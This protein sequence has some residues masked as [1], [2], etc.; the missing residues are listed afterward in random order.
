MV[1]K[2]ILSLAVLGMLTSCGGDNGTSKTNP[3]MEKSTL[4]YQA[5]D[6]S[7]IKAEHFLPAFKAGMAE[8]LSEI[9]SIVAN[10]EAPSF[11]NTIVAL[12]KS[13]RLLSRTSMTF[14]GLSGAHG[15]DEIRKVQTEV[16]PLLS[17]H[18][19]KI[20]LNDKL[21]QRIKAV[22]ENEK[23]SLQGEDARLLEVTYKNFV[24]QGAN[25]SKEDKDKL[26]AINSEL[27]VL[28]NEF[29]D[30]VQD[31]TL[32]ASP[33]IEDSTR[34]KGLSAE[35]IAQAKADAEEAGHKGK[36]MLTL[37]NFTRSPLLSQLDDRELRRELVEASLSR[38]LKGDKN[39][40]QDLVLKITKLRAEKAALLGYPNYASWSMSDQMA[41][42][43]E[44]VVELMNKL[45]AAYLPKAKADAQMLEEF[46]QKTEGKD[47]KLEAW[48]WDYY[49]EKLRKEKFDI[50][51]AALKP[52]FVLDSVLQNGVFYMAN[53][54]YGLTFKERTD[55]PVYLEGVRTFDVL[56]KDGKQLALFYGDYHRRPTKRGGAWMSNWVDQ[57]HL[58]G[59]IPVIYNVCNFSP[60]TKDGEPVLLNMDEVETM[61]HEFGHA[62]HGFFANQKYP[63][64][65]G[66][67][68]S[69]DFVEMPSQFHEHWVLNPEVLKNYAKHYQTGEAIPD[70][71]VEKLK[72]SRQF[73]QAYALG[74][75]I[76]AVV[77]DLD[78]HLI[79]KETNVTSVADFERKALEKYNMLNAQ[80]PPRYSSNYF[81]HSMEGGYS[82]GYYSY[83][84]SEILDNN[85]YDWFEANGGLT[86]E[87]GEDFRAKILSQGNSKKLMQIFQDLTGQEKPKVESLM[88]ARGI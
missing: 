44:V 78:W 5:P 48:D 79:D 6:F 87:N 46:A 51:E 53:R 81:R 56:D 88:K 69:R 32:A 2:T 85:I 75:N 60:A 26:K 4:A 8:Q 29:G 84:W 47:F 74:E 43:P 65:S 3:L 45:V 25:L 20:S 73:N 55:L 68:V 24:S 67:A 50:D 59:T 54:L 39:D 27:A 80:I 70:A 37:L 15:T 41:E 42:R 22:Y 28:T 7:K 49:A 17:E 57:S 16:T 64:L 52:Y 66:T 62:L 21:F 10:P 1:K 30:K 13:G 35:A 36:Y 18:Q 9:D 19:D 31:A 82:A 83:L 12:E 61:F 76:A 14:Y 38:G 71:L 11:E 72:A 58:F 34:L 86:R 77:I 63:S 23:D 40:T 33:I